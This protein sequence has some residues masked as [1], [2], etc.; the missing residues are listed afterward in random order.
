MLS[1]TNLQLPFTHTTRKNK[2]KPDIRVLCGASVYRIVGGDA[3]D[4]Q[5]FRATAVEFEWNRQT[6]SV[7]VKREVIVSA[8][9][10]PPSRW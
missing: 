1:F 5:S 9:Y 8:G 6:H 4:D 7:G 3:G 2:D 10:V